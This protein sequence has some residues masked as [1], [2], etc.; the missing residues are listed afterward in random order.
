[1]SI[2]DKVEN[3]GRLS[4]AYLP[5]PIYKLEKISKEIGKNIWIKRDDLTGTETSG[6]KI[7]KLE[8]TFYKAIQDKADVIITAGGVQS[9]HARAVAAVSAR[10]GLKSHLV[11]EGKSDANI[12][13]NLLL[14]LM[15]GAKVTF[16]E[17]ENK[18]LRQKMDEIALEYKKKGH[19]PYIIPVGASDG[20]G[21]FG[22]INAIKEI[23]E[24]EKTIG[25]EFDHIVCAAGSGGT[26]S[27]LFLGN[28]IF[29]LSKQIIGITVCD[30]KEYF[31]AKSRS[32]IEETG[33]ILDE[34]F[35]ADGLR[36][37]DGY[38]GRGY[39]LSSEDELKFIS[40]VAAKEG[41]ILDPV[42]TGK[43]FI[44]MINEIKKGTFDDSNNIL[45]IHTGGLF[46]LFPKQNQIADILR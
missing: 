42:Y 3:I 2:K 43:A 4:L 21:N 20:I 40:E 35:S 30:N 18:I 39:A 44:G 10:L 15:F 7:R 36:F 25:T 16:L 24:Q 27:G 46:G 22:Y 13:G 37:I 28:Q 5:T 31:E 23:H 17:E 6:N 34:D 45:F 33:R 9:N 19:T 29:G 11:L 41:V 38:K 14:D 12:E 32:I 8:Y 26:Y 1:M